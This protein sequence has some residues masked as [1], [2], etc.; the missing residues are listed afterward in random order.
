MTA[1]FLA[2]LIPIPGFSEPFSSLSHLAGAVL[3]AAL[4]VPLLRRAHKGLSDY[5]SRRIGLLIFSFGAVFLL[6]MS[7]VYHLLS[8]SGA[9]RQVLQRLDHAAIFVLIASS[10]TPIH[11]ILFRGWGKWGV[12]V[13]I[14]SLA[15]TAIVLKTVYFNEM[16]VMLGL[17][18]YLGLGWVGLGT[19]IAIWRRRG[20]AFVA[21]ILWGGL[22]YSIG[23]VLEFVKSPIII[24]GVIQWHEVFHIAVL[25]GLA[26]HWSFIYSIADAEPRTDRITG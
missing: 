14:W 9:G 8:P 25:M 17:L 5:R 4:T 20:F 22:A 3:F 24:P 16:P 13:L 1:A 2:K 23:A 7:G 18:M 21:P 15:I 11:L 12:L 19:G 6:S 10:F 26:F